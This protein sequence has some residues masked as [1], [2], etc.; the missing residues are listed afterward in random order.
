M[1]VTKLPKTKRRA[2]T[3]GDRAGRKRFRIVETCGQNFKRRKQTAERWEADGWR[4]GLG[5]MQRVL[6]RL[7]RVMVARSVFIV[8]DEAAAQ[9]LLALGVIATTCP[10]GLPQWRSEFN[11]TLASKKI[12]IL[13]RNDAVGRLKRCRLRHPSCNLRH[14]S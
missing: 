5:Q 13:P 1:P 14:P 12:A 3:Y 10:F 8:P 4:K 6:Y 7:R 9:A 11:T 2:F